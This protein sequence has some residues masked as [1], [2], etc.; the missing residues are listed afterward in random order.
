VRGESKGEG[1]RE[2]KGEREGRRGRHHPSPWSRGSATGR[3]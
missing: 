1:R 2:G 3:Q